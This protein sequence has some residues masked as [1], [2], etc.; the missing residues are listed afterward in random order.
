MNIKK[1]LNNIHYFILILIPA[2]WILN[3]Y[4]YYSR[5]QSEG[6][7]PWLQIMIPVILVIFASVCFTTGNYLH[8]KDNRMSILFFSI[9]AVLAFYSINCT[10]AGQYW[11]QVVKNQETEINEN[12]KDNSLYLVERYKTKIAEKEEEYKKLNEIKDN[13]INDL[14]DLYGF[15]NTTKTVEEMKDKIEADIKELETELEKILNQN[16]ISVKESEKKEKSK[17]LYQFY[18][19]KD[20]NP[21]VIQ[22]IFQV[23]L[24]I[25][26]ELIAQMSIYIFMIIEDDRK[27][28]IPETEPKIITCESES[29][30]IVEVE[31]E[32]EPVDNPVISENKIT[33]DE[34]KYFSILAWEGIHREWYKHLC[35]KDMIIGNMPKFKQ[36]NFT[37]EKYNK[38]INLA[39]QNK[40]I[41][42]VGN[43]YE[44]YNEFTTNEYFLNKMKSLL[45]LT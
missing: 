17:T 9:Y 22:F 4:Y 35:E 30:D 31:I 24:S 19:G 20:G 15:K 36:N 34:L 12:V 21:D 25:I 29:G 16:M 38:I 42:E 27:H 3:W 28:K 7:A 2:G 10:T 1:I 40:L 18:A 32:Q 39:L 41:K 6:F 26:I 33:P 14:S 44:Q 37:E 45:N 23:M 5:F 43:N 8:R 13:S 11:S